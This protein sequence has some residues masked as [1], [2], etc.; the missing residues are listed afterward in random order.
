MLYTCAVCSPAADVA[1][2]AARIAPDRQTRSEALAQADQLLR[3][4]IPFIPLT[5]PVRWSLV[6][7]RLTGF[8]PNPFG[9]HAAGELIARRR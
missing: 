9:R 3:D 4:A 6:S 5:A 8:Q 2:D 1:M 7:P